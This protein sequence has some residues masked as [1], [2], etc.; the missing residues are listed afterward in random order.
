MNLFRS[1]FR[2][3]EFLDELKRHPELYQS[4]F[5]KLV[6]VADKDLWAR[7][8]LNPKSALS[9][10]GLEQIEEEEKRTDPILNEATAKGLNQIVLFVLYLQYA[11]SDP[12]FDQDTKKAYWV[13]VVQNRKSVDSFLHHNA[14]VSILD[15]LGYIAP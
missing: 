2:K 4:F 5:D 10:D 9:G 7:L 13:S 15:K 3:D 14:I 11:T 6:K 1:W 8:I 12:L